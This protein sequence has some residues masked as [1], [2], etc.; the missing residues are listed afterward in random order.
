[1]FP[2][3]VDALPLDIGEVAIA[4]PIV[5]HLPQHLLAGLHPQLDAGAQRRSDRGAGGEGADHHQRDDQAGGIVGQ[6]G[7]VQ[8][9][10]IGVGAT[11]Q[12]E[13][14]LA[15][16]APGF[17]QVVTVAVVVEAAFLIVVLPLE[18]DR[19]RT[20]LS[21]RRYRPPVVRNALPTQLATFVA[22]LQG[23]PR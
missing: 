10:G 6:R 18:A 15:G 12:A 16:I 7:R 23:V 20:R 1:M 11:A 13:R 5:L 9:V 8:R 14:V 17:R 2:V 21:F 22:Q 4:V 19:L 3:D